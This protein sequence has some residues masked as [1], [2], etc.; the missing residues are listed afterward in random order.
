MPRG[1]RPRSNH[2]SQ[3]ATRGE[4]TEQDAAGKW[5]AHITN[6]LLRSRAHAA[7]ARTGCG[8]KG[9]RGTWAAGSRT[10]P[11]LSRRVF[12]SSFMP[13]GSRGAAGGQQGV[14]RGSVGGQKG[15]SRGFIGQV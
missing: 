9:I 6:M 13:C 3:D 2:R 5:S 12:P 14:R 4:A 7:N 1:A 8:G 10:S 11:P 15:V